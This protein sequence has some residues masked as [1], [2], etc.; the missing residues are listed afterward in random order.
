MTRW[1]HGDV[2]GEEPGEVAAHSLEVLAQDQPAGQAVVTVPAV[3]VRVDGDLLANREPLH[4]NADGVDVAHQ[5]MPGDQRELRL[6]FAVVDVQVGAADPDLI[7]LDP[8]LTRLRF[9]G[10]NLLDRVAAGSVIHDCLH[11][12]SLA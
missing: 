6:E 8:N 12:T 5:L 2:L 9:R 4:P 7:D 1:R 11:R 10:G 3:D